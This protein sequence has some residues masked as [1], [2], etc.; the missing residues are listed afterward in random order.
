MTW[1]LWFLMH[2]FKVPKIGNV[3]VKLTQSEQRLLETVTIWQKK[4]WIFFDVK[5]TFKIVILIILIRKRNIYCV[6]RMWM[7]GSSHSMVGKQ[8]CKRKL[9]GKLSCFPGPN[10][11]FRRFRRVRADCTSPLSYMQNFPHSICCKTSNKWMVRKSIYLLTN[12]FW[13]ICFFTEFSEFSNFPCF[14]KIDTKL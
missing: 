14:S 13:E 5:M 1:I 9:L 4:S 7:N 10:C 6:E 12:Q 2:F 8:R 3:L 11:H